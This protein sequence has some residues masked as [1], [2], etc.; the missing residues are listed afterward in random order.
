MVRYSTPVTRVAALPMYDLPELKEH[1]DAL[2]DALSRELGS[3]GMVD[4]PTALE[5]SLAPGVCWLHQGLLLGQS[6]GYPLLHTL[7]ERVRVV[8]R[9]T[10]R[11]PGCTPGSYVSAV[12]A[13]EGAA[14]ELADLAG[15]R[16]ASNALDSHSGMNAL[17]AAVAPHATDGRFFSEVLVT[18]SHRAS[19]AALREGRADVAAID[20]V[21][22][23][24][25]S[26]VAAGEL[27]GLERLMWTG[28]APT[29][30]LITSAGTD[31]EELA[32]LRSALSRVTDAPGI[33][34]SLDALRLEG[35]SPAELDDYQPIADMV[36][37]A[38]RH[39][40][41]RLR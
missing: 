21:T 13:R 16:A 6:C 37:V 38:L 9:P 26:D 36:A 25:I 40:Y 31:D 3:L 29:L 24:L 27:D 7:S 5:R 2:W 32:I 41:P 18:G 14:S 15:A 34:S 23:A 30:P 35:F 19:L 22:L 4:V 20:A 28:A 12:V 11:A 39:D 1:T 17:R 8:A 33:A 10:Y